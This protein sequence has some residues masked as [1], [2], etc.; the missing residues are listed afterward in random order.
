VD[1]FCT[2]AIRLIHKLQVTKTT[3]LDVEQVRETAGHC[4]ASKIRTAYKVTDR[5]NRKATAHE[6]NADVPRADLYDAATPGRVEQAI[7]CGLINSAEFNLALLVSSFSLESL[8]QHRSGRRAHRRAD[9]F[10]LLRI[11]EH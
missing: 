9:V 6:R 7:D 3:R 5:A 10:H 1:V 4:L 2:C 11:P 8:A